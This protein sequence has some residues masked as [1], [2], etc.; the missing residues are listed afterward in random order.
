MGDLVQ[1]KRLK[2]ALFP[3]PNVVLF[4]RAVLPLH[5]FE[6]RYRQMTAEVLA[7]DRQVA[8]ALLKPGW[9]KNYHGRADIHPVV[10]L[11]TILSHEQL[12]DGR[13]NFL[14]QGHTRARIVEESTGRPYRVATLEPLVETPILEID[15]S[16]ERRRLGELLQVRRLAPEGLM[17]QFRRLHAREISTADLADLCAFTFLEDVRLKQSLLEDA[18]CRRRV[19][20]TI[21]ALRSMVSPLERFPPISAG[22]QGLN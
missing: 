18:D 3:L 4:P 11:G 14:L 15:L 17:D 8:M 7:G 19:R 22:G 9:E 5:I 20:R 21:D 16:D 2:A 13:Y 6:Q 10:C 1:D 12:P